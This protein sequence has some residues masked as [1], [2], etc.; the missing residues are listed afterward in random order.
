MLDQVNTLPRTLPWKPAVLDNLRHSEQMQEL[1][2]NTK[3]PEK[4]LILEND[5][6][7]LSFY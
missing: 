2:E 7:R 1:V 6:S 4:F 5:P 3:S